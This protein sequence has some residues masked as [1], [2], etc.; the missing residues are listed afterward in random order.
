M[1][2]SNR[3]GIAKETLEIVQRGWYEV[4]GFGR[5]EVNQQVDA[6]LAATTLIRPSDHDGPSER[7][8]NMQASTAFEVRN[9]TTLTAAHRL[10]AERG[11]GDVLL[12]NFA[13]AKNPG[14]GFLG[15]SQAQEESLARSSA[16][17]ASL[18][19][20]ADYYE[21]NRGCRTA[22]YTDYMILSPRVPVLRSDDGQ[23][24][25]APYVVGILTSPAVNAGAVHDNEPANV[26]RI[27]P[28]MASRIDKVLAVA[29]RHA[30][31]HL[32][33]GAWGCGV[34]RNDPEAI[35]ELFS[36]ALLGEGT[37]RDAFE[38]VTF[39]VL[40][41]TKNESIF[42]PFQQRFEGAFQ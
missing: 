36:E 6:C 5:V 8:A 28:T 14:G 37:Y 7:D 17:Y 18:Q 1:S 39:A 26:E 40:D 24:L 34:F 32:V 4:D 31:R 2:R 23:L 35:A 25:S 19:T 20:Q 12:L 9:E 11:L 13:S 21:A 38:S 22:L 30:Y 3:A 27:L 29:V 15:G 16:L 42:R 10:V 41:G 33:L